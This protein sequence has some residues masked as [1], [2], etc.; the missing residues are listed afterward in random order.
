[1]VSIYKQKGDVMEC[2]SYRG[3]ELMEPAMKV[4]ETV[5]YVKGD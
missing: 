4:L 1:M 5:V 2:G 3:I